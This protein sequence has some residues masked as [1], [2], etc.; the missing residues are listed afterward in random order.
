MS[1]VLNFCSYK[2]KT[3][4]KNNNAHTKLTSPLKNN[5]YLFLKFKSFNI[6]AGKIKKPTP[7]T[8]TNKALIK[9][10]F[11]YSTIGDDFGDKVE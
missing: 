4:I 3:N 9:F 1:L 10:L 5:L 6:Y 8:Q 2:I 7:T 11:T